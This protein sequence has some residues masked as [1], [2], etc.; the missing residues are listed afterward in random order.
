MSVPQSNSTHTIEM[1]MPVGLVGGAT[2]T[3]PLARL[4]LKRRLVSVAPVAIAALLLGACAGHSQ[5]RG[6]LG[7][8]TS[9]PIL[10][11]DSPD[12]AAS[13]VARVRAADRSTVEV[14]AAG[15]A[16]F[17]FVLP[18]N[19]TAWKVLVLAVTPDDRFGLGSGKLIA[20]K[21][22]ELRPVMPNQV[23]SGDRF[24]DNRVV[25]L[26]L[27]ELGRVRLHQ[28]TGTFPEPVAV[29]L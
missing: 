27:G 21:D 15:K 26:Q 17:D 2:K 10:W 24:R 16:S 11:A 28:I 22:T 23:S 7:V 25:T 18:D 14:D 9:L 1:P 8:M 5:T 6:N 29:G 19:L 4:A 13:L 3:H 12:L 20:T